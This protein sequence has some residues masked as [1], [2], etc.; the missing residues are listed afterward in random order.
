MVICHPWSTYTHGCNRLHFT[1]M[2]DPRVELSILVFSPLHFKSIQNP[3]W[4]F[5][6]LIIR[7]KINM[8]VI[9]VVTR[10]MVL[11]AG[12]DYGEEVC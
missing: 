2:D 11:R 4:G 6:S 5:K 1:I 9:V 3:L 8:R 7:C 12:L 10:A